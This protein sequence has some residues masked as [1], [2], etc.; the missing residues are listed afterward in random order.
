MKL[1]LLSD[2]HANA[3]ALEACLAH[4]QAQGANQWALLGDL[5]GYG[6]EPEAV[7]AQCQQQR[8]RTMALG[9]RRGQCSTQPAS[10]H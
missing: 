10:C 9:G 6:P 8:A 5:V 3:R 4:A 1:A 2:L 7:V